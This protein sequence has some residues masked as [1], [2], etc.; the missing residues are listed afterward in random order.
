MSTFIFH[1][2]QKCHFYS[3]DKSQFS[4]LV[5]KYAFGPNLVII[6][7]ANTLADNEF[8]PKYKH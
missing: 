4:Y 1:L 6:T 5:F 3:F 7:V 2:H 8:W